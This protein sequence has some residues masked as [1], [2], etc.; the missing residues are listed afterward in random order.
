MNKLKYEDSEPD[1]EFDNDIKQ[2]FYRTFQENQL[3]Y[4]CN[5]T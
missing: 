3:D 2:S 4:L 1:L 5:R